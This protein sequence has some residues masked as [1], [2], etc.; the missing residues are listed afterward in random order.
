MKNHS[1]WLKWAGL[2]LVVGLLVASPLNAQ[3]LNM[4]LS[5]NED[6][7]VIY[8]SAFEEDTG[9]NVDFVRL[10]SGSAL[11]K[12]QAEASNPQVSIWYGGT[13][14]SHIVAGAQG[15]LEPYTSPLDALVPDDPAFK[16]L[17]N[18]NWT[19]IYAGYIAFSSNKDFLASNNIAA[20]QSWQ[21]LLKPEFKGKIAM[22]FPFSSGTAY[23]V[24]ATLLQLGL[25]GTEP[26]SPES[27][28]NGF[29]FAKQLDEQV[30][31]YLESGS[32]CIALSGTGEFPVCISFAH[33]IAAKGLSKGLPIEMSFPSEGT[34]SEIGG[35]ALIK[36]GPETASLARAF[37]DWALSVRAQNLF[38]QKFRVPLNVKATV[39]EGV[40]KASD[41]K[42]AD[43]DGAWA[44]DNREDFVQR[45]RDLTGN[46]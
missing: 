14:S 36:G 7:G 13:N 30:G 9:V 46:N 21:D 8:I 45:W 19:G 10:S 38:Q 2:L 17:E 35:M 44:G 43:F 42:L 24:L 18:R 6:E 34:G 22:A 15:L 11:A 37:Y 40:V 3:T 41:V 26:R 33:D 32:G 25:G 20:P 28:E 16:D 27:V 31:Q 29:A 12:V 39:G 4:L 5:F 1:A 23:T